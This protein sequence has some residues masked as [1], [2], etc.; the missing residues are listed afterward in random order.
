MSNEEIDRLKSMLQ[1]VDY[2]YRSLSDSVRE[3]KIDFELRKKLQ[4]KQ[5]RNLSQINENQVKI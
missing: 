3:S 2:E 1:S 5:E 4:E